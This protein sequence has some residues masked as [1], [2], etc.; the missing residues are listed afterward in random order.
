M[1]PVPRT[2]YRGWQKSVRSYEHP[3]E[4]A[5]RTNLPYSPS[6][7]DSPFWWNQHQSLHHNHLV[8]FRC[9]Q[10]EWV[11]QKVLG[12]ASGLRNQRDADADADADA[13]DSME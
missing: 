5:V 9:A 3:T 4:L 2:T 12:G 8:G 6:D 10:S 1:D 7:N 13:A 11:V